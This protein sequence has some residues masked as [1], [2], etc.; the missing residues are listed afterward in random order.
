MAPSQIRFCCATMGT[1]PFVGL[2]MMTILTS[3]RWYLI[4][5]LICMSL[6]ISDVE[7][8]FICLHFLF[9][10][11]SIQIAFPF[12][13]SFH[14]GEIEMNLTSIHEDVGL[15]PGLSPWIKDLALP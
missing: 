11:M 7:H 12:F 2:L 10:K 15:I 4:V 3:V 14:H 9:A 8:F 6:I 1:P 13:W 5:G